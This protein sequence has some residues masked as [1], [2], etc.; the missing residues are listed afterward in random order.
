MTQYCGVIS[1]TIVTQYFGVKGEIEVKDWKKPEPMWCDPD[2]LRGIRESLEISQ[3]Q[4][5]ERSGVSRALIANVEAGRHHLSAVDGLKMY[6]A[7]AVMEVER[8][9]K[10]KYFLRPGY[11]PTPG[12]PPHEADRTMMLEAV[13]AIHGEF[14][15]AIYRTER[16]IE[17]LQKKISDYRR[18]QAQYQAEEKWIKSIQPKNADAKRGKGGSK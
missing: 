13:M 9:G 18:Y 4:L 16:E 11:N 12:A 2:F 7:L 17:T 14:G 3:A 6:G 5:S 8:T 10:A 15:R 1:R